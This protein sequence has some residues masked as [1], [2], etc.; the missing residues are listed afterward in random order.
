MIRTAVDDV[1]KYSFLVL[2]RGHEVEIQLRVPVLDHACLSVG[3]RRDHSGWLQEG[4]QFRIQQIHARE[5]VQ[6]T[7]V[8][9][10]RSTAFEAT[11]K[12]VVATGGIKR[13]YARTA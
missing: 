8:L 6:A 7:G 9:A 4:S 1:V 10:R 5:A 2:A 11:T 12:F 13:E 3:R